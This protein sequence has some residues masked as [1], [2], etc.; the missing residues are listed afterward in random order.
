MW[1]AL[2]YNLRYRDGL[3][4]ISYN[5]TILESSSWVVMREKSNGGGAECTKTVVY[6]AGASQATEAAL[7]FPLVPS[8]TDLSPSLTYISLKL[9][10]TCW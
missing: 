3:G 6:K 10:V 5:L 4:V 8:S 7:L 9:G 2:P 1:E